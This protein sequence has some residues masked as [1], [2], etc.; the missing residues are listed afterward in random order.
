MTQQNEDTRKI[1]AA[2][3]E[4]LFLEACANADEA[5]T[6]GKMCAVDIARLALDAKNDAETEFRIQI[7]ATCDEDWNW[8]FA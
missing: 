7:T 5:D 3:A 8:R 4:A 6:I 2:R 1:A